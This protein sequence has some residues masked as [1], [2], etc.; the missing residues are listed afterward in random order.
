MERGDIEVECFFL[1][2]I[3]RAIRFTSCSLLSLAQP[4]G[5]L[6]NPR[7]IFTLIIGINLKIYLESQY[8]YKLQANHKD[9]QRS[10]K[11]PQSK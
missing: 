9:P 7:F 5:I 8:K 1:G 2:R 6:P 4:T 10:H 11:V 3:N